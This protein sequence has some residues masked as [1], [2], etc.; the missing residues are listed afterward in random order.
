MV[1][2]KYEL[3]SQVN[4]MPWR[5][6]RRKEL[7][8]EFSTVAAIIALVA[9]CLLFAA[10]TYFVQLQENQQS[11]LDYVDKKISEVEKKIVELETL[12]AEK[13]SLLARISAIEELQ[14]NRP[15]PVRMMDELLRIMPDGMSF[16]NIV[17]GQDNVKLFGL[18]RSNA[19]VSALM[20]S[21]ES[22]EWLDAP[23]LMKIEKKMVNIRST[24]SES[25]RIVNYDENAVL[26]DSE[27]YFVFSTFEVWFKL[28]ALRGTD[29]SEEDLL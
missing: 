1:A 6:E 7:K 8:K 2:A 26:K 20:R 13:E 4:L 28:V 23:K 10:H 27:G 15:L 18:A 29:E 12:E 5:E 21:M 14:G 25:F 11:R 9:G 16:D 19:V 24:A 17:Q 3:V 22:S